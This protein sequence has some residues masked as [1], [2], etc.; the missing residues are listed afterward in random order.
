MLDVF[1]SVDVEIWC[2]DW[3]RI[4]EEFPSAF[5]KFIYGSTPAGDYGL[6]YKIKV[7]NDHGLPG[8]FFIEPLFALRFGTDPLAEIVGLVRE[9]GQE[10]QLHLHTEWVDE[11]IPPLIEGVNGK[12]Q[13]LKDFSLE[14]QTL[15]IEEGARLLKQAGSGDFNAFRAGSFGFNTDTLR[16]IS[17]NG[18]PFDSSYNAR[19]FGPES[20]VMPGIAIEEPIEYLGIYEYPMTIF[21]D[22][23]GSLRNAQLTACSYREM[24]GLLWQAL[25]SGRKSFMIL[26]HGSELLNKDNDRPDM[27]VVD[28]FRKLCSFLDKNRESFRVRGFKDL[29]PKLVQQQPAQLTSPLW[30]TCGRMAEQAFRMRYR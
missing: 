25:D 19:R 7:L 23:T 26:S 12:R 4:D 11:A 27:V 10:T 17:A 8:I 18:I 15:L 2:D 22:G 29:Q 14:E 9:G 20:G 24:E 3:N 16:A 28:R 21:R 1:F 6:P 30:R 5:R 13:Y